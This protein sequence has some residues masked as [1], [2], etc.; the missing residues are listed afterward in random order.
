VPTAQEALNGLDAVIGWKEEQQEVE[1]VKIMHL[2][3]LKNMILQKRLS[4]K[5]N[6]I[7]LTFQRS[8]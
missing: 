4:C 5:N 7:L 1:Q 3:S 2:V 8:Y 6:K